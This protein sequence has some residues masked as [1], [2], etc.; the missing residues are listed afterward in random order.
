MHGRRTW[1]VW[2]RIV[3][4]VVVVGSLWNGSCVF[5]WQQTDVLIQDGQV[6]EPQPILEVDLQYEADR[7]PALHVTNLAIKQGYAPQYEPLESGYQLL[8]VSDH[9]AILSSLT[10]TIPNKV[11][12]PPPQTGDISHDESVYL[13]SIPF[14]LTVPMLPNA[15]EVRVVDPQGLVIA[16]RSLVNI[17]VERHP[18]Q[19]RTLPA[20]EA[21]PSP[22][23]SRKWPPQRRRFVELLD[24]MMDTAEA[25][26]LDGLALDVTFVGH[27]YTTAG[28]SLFHQDVDRIIAYMLTFEPYKSRASQVQFHTVDNT[29]VDL[30]CVRSATM[31]RLITCNNTTVTSVVNNA[32]APYDKIVVLV[33]DPIYGG[34]G[35][36]IAVSYNGGSAPQVVTHEFGHS[37]GGLL[38]EYNLYATNGALDGN[39]YANCYAG[40]PPDPAWD[41]IVPL[42]D[43]V[44]GCKYPNWYRPSPCSIMLNLSCEYFNSVSQQALNT[45][46]N[47]YAGGGTPTLTLT[48]TPSL[49]KPGDSS[50]LAWTATNVSGCTAAGA[51]S[52]TESL[53]GTQAVTPSATAIF[54]LNCINGTSAISQSAT[55]IVD[56]LIPTVTLTAPSS[57]STVSGTVTLNVTATD[58]QAM[59]RVD[60]FRDGILLGS[61]NTVPYS[62]SWN[63]TLESTGS[64]V[65]SVTAWDGAGNASTSSSVTVNVPQQTIVKGNHKKWKP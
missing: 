38:D 18:R 58:N 10:F 52:G 12:N 54:A 25:A 57:G 59:G 33:N 65:L 16:E 62:L 8:L 14:S 20:P 44:S 3:R 28:L 9:E 31:D 48:V 41:G 1:G 43:Y 56:A 5:A 42:S 37:F 39:T 45:K 55:V 50:T 23:Q 4:L 46:L 19:F 22:S 17:S 49:I 30:G 11:Y 15:V 47:L 32:G 21:V 6:I 2:D 13:K 29:T 36:S 24:W 34:S 40:T 64:H 53:S 27:Q 35:G 63:S 60:F 51:W 26:T 7:T 61:D